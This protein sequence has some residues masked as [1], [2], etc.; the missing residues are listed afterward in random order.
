[1]GI[2]QFR[3]KAISINGLWGFIR[4][5]ITYEG[6]WGILHILFIICIFVERKRNTNNL[7]F[8]HYEK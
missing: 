5:S 2:R 8:K 7:I 1:M 4:P 6:K 3:I